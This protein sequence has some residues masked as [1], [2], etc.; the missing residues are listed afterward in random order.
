MKASRCISFFVLILALSAP[1]T[2]AWSSSGGAPCGRETPTAG[3]QAVVTKVESDTVTLQSL[4]DDKKIIIISRKDAGQ[5]RTGDRVILSGEKVTKI[6]PG[7]GETSN[8]D[9]NP[10]QSEAKPEA[11]ESSSGAGGASTAP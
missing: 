11:P 8:P 6:E 3:L 10:A 5:L 7:S 9:G 4:G 2:T 1:A